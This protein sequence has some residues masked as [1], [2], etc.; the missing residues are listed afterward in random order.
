MRKSFAFISMIIVAAFV[1]VNFTSCDKDDPIPAPTVKI[2]ADIDPNDQYTV[3]LTVQATDAESYAWNYGDGE[4]S[5][6]SGNHSHTYAASGD[7]K[8]SVTVT[9][10]TG[11]ASASADITINPS[12]QEMLAGVD[13]AGKQWVLSTT[14]SADDGVGP[15]AETE[16]T[17]NLP[18]ALVGGDLLGYVQLPDEYDN[19]FT[20]KP[21]GSYSV[22]NVNGQNL[23]TAIKA[24]MTTG[25]PEP[26]NSWT[27]GA[28][29]FATMAYSVDSDAKWTVTEDAT[30][31]FAAMSED[32]TSGEANPPLTPMNVSYKGVTQLSISGNGYFGLLDMTNYVMI[33]SITPEKLQA[34]IVAHTTVPDKPSIFVRITMVPKK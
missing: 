5:T 1:A 24:V 31:A 15:L 26:G 6:A 10:G 17:V 32:P 22:D 30:I 14:A 7:Y 33:R 19:V 27:Y 13:A 20:F 2:L 11:T 25:E 34:D 18:V 9:N 8:I 29:G 28:L 16:L 21:D 4:S 23:C 12:I 3:T